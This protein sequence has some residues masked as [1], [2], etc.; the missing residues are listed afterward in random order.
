[1]GGPSTPKLAVLA[2][3]FSFAAN[4]TGSD[5]LQIAPAAPDELLR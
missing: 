1:M 4:L 2:D 3:V 5:L